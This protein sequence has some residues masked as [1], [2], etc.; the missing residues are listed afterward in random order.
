MAPDAWT[1]LK[2]VYNVAMYIH[3]NHVSNW[4]ERYSLPHCCLL[5]VT[6]P[7]VVFRL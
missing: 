1:W 4:R 3:T 6:L 7:A 2:Q 5:S